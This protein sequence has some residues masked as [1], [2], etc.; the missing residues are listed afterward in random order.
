[1][2]PNQNRRVRGRNR[3]KGPNPLTRSYESN[4]PDVKVRGTAQHI[5][6][7][8]AQLARDAQAAGDPVAAENYFQH[9][10][11]YFRIISGAQEQGRPQ[12]G[13]G[14]ASRAYDDDMEDGDD[15]QGGEANGQGYAGYAAEYGDP[16]QQPQPYDNRGEGGQQ[17]GRQD[18]NQN[19]RGQ[20]DRFGQNQNRGDRQERRDRFQ[21]NR[22]DRPRFDNGARFDNQRPDGNRQ[23]GNRLDQPR[24]ENGQ[25]SD[26][27]RQD[28]PRQTFNRQENGRQENGRQEYPRQENRQESRQENRQENRAEFTRRDQPRED[29]SR[30]D[31]SR[32]EQPRTDAPRESRHENGRTEQARREPRQDVRTE[33]P[34]RAEAPLRA[35]APVR[36]DSPAPARRERRREEPRAVAEDAAGLPAF[37]MTPPRLPAASEAPAVEAQPSSQP[38]TDGD[39]A[40]APKVRRR[41]RPRFEGIETEGG[42]EGKAPDGA[43]SGE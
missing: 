23:D 18:R 38:P 41:R 16:G 35:E 30:Q 42:A 10:E 13:A 43:G 31:P 24:Q 37:L 11:H 29:V 33:I 26:Y 27:D 4:G 22:N 12:A 20:N 19:D 40:P 15:E 39:E 8:Y 14:Y 1:M 7:K 9:G 32:Q 28:A 5:A 25:R 6:D 17:D 21:N 34:V 2:R 36:P 3:P